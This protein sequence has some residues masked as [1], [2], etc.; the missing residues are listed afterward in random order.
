MIIPVDRSS[1]PQAATIHS[2]S[3][4]ESHRSFCSPDFVALHTPE[5]QLKYLSDKI[6]KGSKLYLLVED[7][8]VGIVCVTGSL[9]E[10]LY[11]LPDKQNLGYGTRLLEFAM[12]KCERIPTLWVLEN[13]RSAQRLYRRMGFRE[14]GKINAGSG[15]LTEI[16][17]AR[18]ASL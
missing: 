14:T 3:W 9:I 1:L 6:V 17:Y 10:D 8:P 15:K 7:A 4:Q 18:T 5:R 12:G 13:N 2:V 16:E 11:V